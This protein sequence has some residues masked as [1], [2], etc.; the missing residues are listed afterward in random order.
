M[1]EWMEWFNG[2]SPKADGL[3]KTIITAISYPSVPSSVGE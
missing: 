3:R 1:I 2:G